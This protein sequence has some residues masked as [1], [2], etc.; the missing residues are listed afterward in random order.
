MNFRQT[1]P[2]ARQLTVFAVTAVLLALSPVT[3]A[4]SHAVKLCSHSCG[5]NQTVSHTCRDGEPSHE[6]SALV[7]CETKVWLRPRSSG[8]DPVHRGLVDS[9]DLSR[10]LWTTESAS[11]GWIFIV[12]RPSSL[13]DKR[14]CY[15]VL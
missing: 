4:G 11:L 12:V 6:C 10:L 7:S 9:S 14:M 8:N 1:N 13:I 15:L 2:A 5:Q 3:Q